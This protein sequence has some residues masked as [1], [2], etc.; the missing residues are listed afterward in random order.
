MRE[1]KSGISYD[2]LKAAANAGALEALGKGTAVANGKHY[3]AKV[4]YLDRSGE[5][6][7]RVYFY[8]QLTETTVGGRD[9]TGKRKL[10]AIVKQWVAQVRED[11][12]SVSRLTADPSLPTRECVKIFIDSKEKRDANGE[13]IGARA[14]TLTF[15][16]SCAKRLD[17]SPALAD[18]P[19]ISVT[20]V[21]VQAWVDEM[22]K[23]LSKKS[24]KDSVNILS[25][26]CREML[27]GSNPCD[28]VSIPKNVR[29]AKQG[30]TSTKP[31][32]LNADAVARL[33]VLLDEREEKADSI[34]P[35]VIGVRLALHT[36]MR[37]EEV[38]GLRWA[39]V[40]LT[41]K[42]IHVCNVIERAQVAE[43]GEDGE[44]R[45]AYR[46]FDAKPKTE[47]SARD[48]PMDAELVR[49]L[50]DHK[51]K[52]VEFFSGNLDERYVIGVGGKH[53]SPHRLGVNFKKWCR[54]RNVIG[55]EG[56]V[57]GFHDLRHTWASLAL[58]AA[59]DQLSEVSALLGHSKIQ[60]TL[61]IYVGR[62]KDEQRA[63]VENMQDV[64]AARTPRDV[65]Q[66]NGTDC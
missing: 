7:R 12:E 51:A 11:I 9:A 34:D 52:V 53:Y 35:F 64:F 28:A 47:G 49:I 48:I 36:G 3:K 65:L 29:Q 61:N 57:I 63:F 62:D 37:A 5:K 8:K 2:R 22:A 18:K 55:T 38:A 1:F 54:V 60:T 30:R 10:D 17:Y 27:D 24:I 20:K 14:S 23:S 6:P 4:S 43:V 32:Y 19:L 42:V 50:E 58:K 41:D 59:P 13:M 31:N 26:T 44:D 40:D 45:M 15:Y 46:E 66:L 21:D 25:Q 56:D 33:N 39:D 16:R